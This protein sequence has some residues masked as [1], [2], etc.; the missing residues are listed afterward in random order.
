MAD[1]DSGRPDPVCQ[2]QINDGNPAE[3]DKQRGRYEFPDD[4]E[5]ER[6]H[7]ADVCIFLLYLP[8]SNRYLLGSQQY[9]PAF[10]AAD[11]KYLPEQ[12]D[13]DELIRKNVEKANKKR[14]KKGLPPQKVNQ[15]ATANLKHGGCSGEGRSGTC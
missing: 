1:P 8:G 3:E 12:V 4:A 13:M 14:A 11:R 9:L 10:A 5:H 2:H 6:Y 7:A 15:N